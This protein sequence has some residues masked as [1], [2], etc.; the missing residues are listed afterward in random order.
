MII[1]DMVWIINVYWKYV[2]IISE[3]LYFSLKTGLSMCGD[4]YWIKKKFYFDDN[5]WLLHDV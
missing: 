3:M 1:Y 2:K 5:Q 4:D